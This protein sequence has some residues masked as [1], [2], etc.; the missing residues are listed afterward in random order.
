MQRMNSKLMETNE[1]GTR[2]HR[3]GAGHSD[4]EEMKCA[5]RA[6]ERADGTK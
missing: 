6:L 4:T 1:E 2:S 3:S 5:R